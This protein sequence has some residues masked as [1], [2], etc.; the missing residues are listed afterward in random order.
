VHF[1]FLLRACHLLAK[2]NANF[3]PHPEAFSVLGD[4]SVNPSD[5]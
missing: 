4:D 3:Y 1:P 5:C 2:R